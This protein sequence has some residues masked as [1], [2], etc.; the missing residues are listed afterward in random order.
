M[1]ALDLALCHGMVGCHGRCPPRREGAKEPSR[2]EKA[3]VATFAG[4]CSTR[5]ASHGRAAKPVF[6]PCPITAIGNVCI[7]IRKRPFAL[8]GVNGRLGSLAVIR[9]GAQELPRTAHFG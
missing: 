5:S 4:L 3:S 8:A 9:Q 6:R 7:A 1:I 2:R